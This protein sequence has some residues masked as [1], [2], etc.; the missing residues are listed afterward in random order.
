MRF[1]PLAA[2]VA[3]S[4]TLIPAAA[5]DA[6][7]TVPVIGGRGPPP[8]LLCG[9][10]PG[11]TPRGQLVLFFVG[12]G[13]TPPAPNAP[14][15]QHA[16]SLGFHFFGLS[17]PDAP[18]VGSFCE[19]SGRQLADPDCDYRIRKI[20]LFGGRYNASTPCTAKDG[21]VEPALLGGV[22]QFSAVVQASAKRG[23][24]WASFTDA[25]APGGIAWSKVVAAGTSQ[26]AGMA[27]LVGQLH[28]LAGVVQLAGV[29]DIN[30]NGADPASTPAPW[31]LRNRSGATPIERVWGLGNVWGFCC[32]YWHAN[33]AAI[34]MLGPL[35]SV[36]GGV[37]GLGGSHKLCSSVNA[38]GISGHGMPHQYPGYGD[39]W[40]LMLTGKPPPGTAGTARQASPGDCSCPGDVQAVVTLQES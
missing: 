5:D 35:A 12:S 8:H 21:C 24:G 3:L 27:L 16:R 15:V 26:G 4:L 13:G 14:F 19:S 25:A 39:A 37:A 23:G 11:S 30:I 29:D 40:T 18:S 38:S 1:A 31:V 36:D 17:Y 9:P 34:G 10:E 7:V 33:W 20:R 28:P 2:A 32:A 6:C 22:A